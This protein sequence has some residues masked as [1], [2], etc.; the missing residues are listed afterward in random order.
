MP[1]IRSLTEGSSTEKFRE[2]ESLE[3]T[4]HAIQF[5]LFLS[6]PL[7]QQPHS[8]TLCALWGFSLP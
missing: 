4:S 6:C 7:Y 8:L 2:S 1:S 3:R 5:A